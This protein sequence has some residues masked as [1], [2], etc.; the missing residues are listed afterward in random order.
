MGIGGLYVIGLTG[1]IAT[2]KSEVLRIL[3]DLGAYV[4][5]A[6][7][8]V[9][10][11]LRRGTP[12]YRQVVEAFGTDILDE[13]GEIDRRRLGARVF[14][15]PEALAR[16][17]RIVHP[18]VIAEVLRELDEVAR[19][20]T[21]RV[22]VV[23]AIKLLEA[24]MADELCDEVWV[25]HA[26]PEQQIARLMATR[27]MTE[28]E[29]RRRL[30]AQ[31]PQEHKEARADWVVDNSG[32]LEDTRRQLEEAWERVLR[33]LAARHGGGEWASPSEGPAAPTT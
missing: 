22:A 14:A 1:N 10:R 13:Q 33:T 4:V 11:L 20:G 8:R 23:E 21:H 29:A 27:G 2:G 6:D 9:H 7:Q 15:D 18:A 26:E 30:A 28:E 5:D 3:R 17:E 32:S 25:V 12:V 31:P 19:R 16:L 24:G